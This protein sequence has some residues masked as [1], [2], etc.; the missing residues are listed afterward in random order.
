MP[1]KS[2]KPYAIVGAEQ[3]TAFLYKTGDEWLGFQYRFNIVRQNSRTGRVGHWLR[4][5]D[6]EALIKLTRV[7]AEELAGDGCMEIALRQ[8]L[9]DIATVLDTAITD[10]SVK[11][12][13][14]PMKDSYENQTRP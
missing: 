10:L 6:I 4:P 1:T 8:R 13:S 7:L 11:P 9:R 2:H 14:K 12:H 3:L 5:T